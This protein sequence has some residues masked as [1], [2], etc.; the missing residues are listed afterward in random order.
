MVISWVGQSPQGCNKAMVDYRPSRIHRTARRVHVVRTDSNYAITLVMAWLVAAAIVAVGLLGSY[1]AEW[2]GDQYQLIHLGKTVADGGRMYVDCWENKPPGLAWL[3]ALAMVAFS[4]S[5]LGAWLLPGAV[6]LAALAAFFAALRSLL[7]RY[8]AAWM[9]PLTA[10]LISQRVYDA[11][12]INPDFY[13]AMFSL[14][15]V[16]LFLLG[17]SASTTRRGFFMALFSGLLFALATSVKQDGVVCLVVASIVLLALTVNAR[18]NLLNRLLFMVLVWLAFVISVGTVVLVLHLRGNLN[19]ARYAVFAFNAGLLSAESLQA[20]ATQWVRALSGMQMMNAYLWLACL[21]VLY[22]V[23][24]RRVGRFPRRFAVVLVGWWLVETALALLGPSG[25]MRYWQAT[26]P[27]LFW[28]AACA[29]RGMQMSYRQLSRRIRPM[30]VIIA[31]TAFALLIMPLIRQSEYELARCYLNYS[32][33]DPERKDLRTLGATIMRE[34]NAGDAIYVLGYDTGVYLYAD[35]SCASRFAYARSA[36][37]A[38]EILRDLVADKTKLVLKPLNR[39]WNGKAYFDEQ[40]LSQLDEFLASCKRLD[41]VGKYIIYGRA[42][43]GDSS[44]TTQSVG[45]SGSG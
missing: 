6:A 2:R 17:S 15:A 22:I 1:W 8:V 41:Q 23:F 11:P 20:I 10:L 28:L 30:A 27:P 32:A 40:M 13:G 25:S 45:T 44:F 19:E 24:L 34:S 42:S 21:G 38:E 33:G 18:I 39:E 37:Q 7:G 35:R 26:W 43:D 9:L 4:G 29:L 12:S 14:M 16:S 3:N 5:Q 31:M 36:A